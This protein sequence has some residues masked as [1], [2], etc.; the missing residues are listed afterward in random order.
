MNCNN[1][2]FD[3]SLG[4]DGRLPNGRHKQLTL[5]VESCAT[6]A[7]MWNEL[8]AAQELAL[9]L[10]TQSTGPTFGES[11]WER[12]RSGEGSPDAMFR[13]P[14]PVIAKV[15]Y[16]LTGAAAAALF[17]A[18][19][20]FIP[21]SPAGGTDRARTLSGE[22]VAA[23]SA[24]PLG[25]P[26]GSPRTNRAEQDSAGLSVQTPKYGLAAMPF[27]PTFV[28]KA[29]AN[30][31]VNSIGDIKRLAPAFDA[32]LA[33]QR[34]DPW[35][36]RRQLQT[37]YRSLRGSTHLMRWLHDSRMIELPVQFRDELG[38]VEVALR[39][40]DDAREP[41]QMRIALRQIQEIDSDQMRGRFHVLCCT[42]PEEFLRSFA[43]HF[44]R[45]RDVSLFLPL[46][47]P[48][49]LMHSA[50]GSQRVRTFFRRDE[51]ALM[52]VQIL[53]NVGPGSQ[54]LEIEAE[55]LEAPKSRLSPDKR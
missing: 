24:T 3:M 52:R 47:I 31:C 20:Q 51:S 29:G 42:E 49:S 10:P 33:T 55:L 14:V 26:D 9:G 50:P 44:Q 18:A 34:I 2:Q 22:S 6:C 46:T 27:E 40:V 38:R 25:V 17:I 54:T 43:D 1:Y 12:I 15:R 35:E 7:Q 8:R 41:Q 39:L 16:V 37:P 36:I 11:L 53:R 21:Q 5:H 4:L 23:G 45:N 30:Q 32:K 19:W 28:A 13:A 48:E